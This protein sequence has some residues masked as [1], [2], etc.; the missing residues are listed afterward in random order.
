[1]DRARGRESF[2]SGAGLGMQGCLRVQP[3]GVAVG[4]PGV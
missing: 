4:T 3:A 1:M 2:L